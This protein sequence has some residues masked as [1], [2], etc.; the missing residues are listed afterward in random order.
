MNSTFRYV[1]IVGL[2]SVLPGCH[3][4]KPGDQ[5]FTPVDENAIAGRIPEPLQIVSREMVRHRFATVN[6]SFF[7]A[8]MMRKAERPVAIDLFDTVTVLLM[9]DS[10]TL[11][12]DSMYVWHGK[13][14]A[15]Y[16][17]NASLSF[18]PHT[19]F[20]VIQVDS[21]VFEIHPV[22]DNIVRISEID[23]KKFPEEAPPIRK[24]DRSESKGSRGETFDRN[25]RVNL[26]VLV[27]LPLPA[28]S[29]VCRG[30]FPIVN[31]LHLFES[32][33][34]SNLNKVFN[35]VNP[36]GI[37]AT[38]V[39]SCYEYK[40][41]GGDLTEDLSWVRTDAGIAALRETH[42]AD[43]VCL[44]V[45]DAD[46]CGRGYENYPVDSGDEG[47]AFSVVK[48]SCA[49]GNY[50][51]AHELSHNIGMRHDRKADDEFG[52]E[53]CNY[54]HIFNVKILGSNIKARTVMAYGSSCDDCPRLGVLSNPTTISLGFVTIGPMG[55]DCSTPPS[56]GTYGRANNRQQLIDAAPV[57]AAFR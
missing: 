44:L 25:E 51:F 45:P 15:E 26:K 2:I 56:S 36:T 11:R 57:V 20:G 6:F 29:F 33:F 7:E 17:G 30:D 47:F 13:P 28:Y 55:V 4:G 5:A 48:A 10:V 23:Q 40:P 37:T 12:D 54:G 16:Y 46:F 42:S 34:Q 18:S 19:I 43:L 27:V 41:V 35:A 38:V 52:S 8:N 31:L 53:T 14:E 32:A 22:V 1:L 3:P 50:S 49:L 24:K 9:T 21:R 39:F